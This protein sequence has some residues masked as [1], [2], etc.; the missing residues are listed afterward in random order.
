MG[1]SFGTVWSPTSTIF[2]LIMMLFLDA[3][4]IF[5]CVSEPW[6]SLSFFGVASGL[7]PLLR[8]AVSWLAVRPLP[9]KNPESL[10]LPVP[11]CCSDSLC[12]LFYS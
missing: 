3:G 5:P 9:L 11:P 12:C 10:S 8:A 7:Q 1:T 2:L 6:V 4:G